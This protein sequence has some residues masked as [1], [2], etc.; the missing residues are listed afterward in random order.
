MKVDATEQVPPNATFARIQ[1]HLWS[2]DNTI[3]LMARVASTSTGAL[4]S[5]VAGHLA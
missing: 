2:D 4:V 3:P 5:E 1:L